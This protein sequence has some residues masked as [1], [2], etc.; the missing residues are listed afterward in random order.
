MM[1]DMGLGLLNMGLLWTTERRLMGALGLLYVR[2][3]S[4][5]NGDV[6]KHRDRL[7]AFIRHNVRASGSHIERQLE[8]KSC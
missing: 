5:S 7:A 6:I 2:R 1:S 3:N 4:C 8:E